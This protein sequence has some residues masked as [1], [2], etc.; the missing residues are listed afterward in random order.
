MLKQYLNVESYPYFGVCKVYNAYDYT[1]TMCILLPSEQCNG[2]YSYFV[3]LYV[4]QIWIMYDIK[5]IDV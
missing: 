1:D 2:F 4:L 3:L 5:L